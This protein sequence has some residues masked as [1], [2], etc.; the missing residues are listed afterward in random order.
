MKDTV[1]A[2]DFFAGIGSGKRGLDA[3][4]MKIPVVCEIE[5]PERKTIKI[6]SPAN[7]IQEFPRDIRDYSAVSRDADLLKI[8]L[9]VFTPPC[10]SFTTANVKRDTTSKQAELVYEALRIIDELKP[11]HLIF[12]NVRG[13]IYSRD[14]NK[15]L[16]RVELEK[17]I[18]NMGFN[19]MADP[20][21][22]HNKYLY[23]CADYG[24][25]QNRIRY[26]LVASK[27]FTPTIPKI[28]PKVNFGPILKHVNRNGDTGD[29]NHSQKLLDR[30]KSIANNVQGKWVN[31]NGVAHSS[32]KIYNTYYVLPGH[33]MGQVPTLGNLDKYTVLTM[34]ANG[35][36]R[37]ISIPEIKALHTVP[38]RHRMAGTKRDK[39]RGLGNVFPSV[40]MYEFAKQFANPRDIIEWD[41]YTGDRLE[42]RI[43]HYFN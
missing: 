43:S 34:G 6:N 26:I 22:N 20:R 24:T 14:R 38:I 3:L 21:T 7:S 36:Y 35:N 9:S 23:S 33:G 18:K 31:K 30:Y 25:P 41:Q 8:D 27:K 29:T 17:A 5:E 28:K 13:F 19:L 15:K 42:E 10:Q 37:V 1:I 40:M 32:T 39:H 11:E 4:G 2:A 12:E 16:Y